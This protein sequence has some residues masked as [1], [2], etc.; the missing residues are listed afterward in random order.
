MNPHTNPTTPELKNQAQ[1]L[2]TQAKEQE[3]GFKQLLEGLSQP[4]STLEAGNLLKSVGSIESKIKR[5]QGDITA[6]GD[7][8]RAA[9]VVEHKGQLNSQL[10]HIEDS[11]RA[12]GVPLS[13]ARMA[14]IKASCCSLCLVNLKMSSAAW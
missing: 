14:L 12:Q 11:L 2:Y 10:M 4:S 8:L 9:I 1:T 7:F 6:I 13:S 5:K 3:Q